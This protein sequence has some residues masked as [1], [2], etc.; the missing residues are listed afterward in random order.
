MVAV[1]KRTTAA[2]TAD[3]DRNSDVLYVTFGPPRAGY[4]EDGPDD[5]IL[6]Y[7]EDDDKPSGV[8]VVG[9]RSNSWLAKSHDLAV[10]IAQH[11]GVSE[12][13]AQ[14]AIEKAAAP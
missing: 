1:A 3:Y 2:L 8:T 4:G 13:D 10:I 6:R 5:V 9:F 12:P 14:Q 7:G 11:L